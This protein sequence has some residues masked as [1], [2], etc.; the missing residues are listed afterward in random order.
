MMRFGLLSSIGMDQADAQQTYATGP[1]YEMKQERRE[2]AMDTMPEPPTKKYR[3]VKHNHTKVQQR[4]L[5]AQ[6]LERGKEFAESAK[7]LLA[8][9]GHGIPTVT[10]IYIAGRC[11][12]DKENVKAHVAA[13]NKKVANLTREKLTSKKVKE[14][15]GAM[16]PSNDAVMRL[17]DERL[18]TKIQLA[19]LSLLKYWKGL[20]IPEGEVAYK[21]ILE[22]A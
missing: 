11:V 8:V 22:R 21:Y 4:Q 10:E 17:G 15:T 1:N 13:E 9:P 14:L 16:Q 12:Q 19:E 20:S 2:T 5:G 6:L 18:I 7:S 3:R